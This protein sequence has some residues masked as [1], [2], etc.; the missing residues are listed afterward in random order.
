MP[1]DATLLTLGLVGAMAAA[2]TASGSRSTTRRRYRVWPQVRNGPPRTDRT[3][4]VIEVERTGPGEPSR[5]AI[6][7]AFYDAHS[8][9]YPLAKDLPDMAQAILFDSLDENIDDWAGIH[10][11]DPSGWAIE[12]LD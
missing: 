11:T 7:Q 3:D 10:G 4:R 5:E 12:P 6:L 9:D 1:N 2:A 8:Y